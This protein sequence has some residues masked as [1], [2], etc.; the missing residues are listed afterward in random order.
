MGGVLL[1]GFFPAGVR[2]HA[3]KQSSGRT[4]QFCWAEEPR[5]AIVIVGQSRRRV[6][7]KSFK[8]RPTK[9]VCQFLCSPWPTR[10]LCRS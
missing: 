6:G 9:C 7:G 4:R 2:V 5:L 3:G 1:V 8:R 10:K